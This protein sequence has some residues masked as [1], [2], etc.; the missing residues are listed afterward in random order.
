MYMKQSIQDQYKQL[1]QEII[2][3]S[4]QYHTHDNPEISDE[5]YDALVRELIHLEKQYP[6]LVTTDT[7]TTRVG[8]KILDGF[9]KINHIVPQWSYDNVFN[10]DELEQWRQR[11]TKILIKDW[12]N[13]K[14]TEYIAELKIDGL[15][16]VLTYQNGKLITGAT[17]GDGAVGENVTE[18]ILQITS[19]PKTISDTRHMVIMGEIWIEKSELEKINIERAMLD[20]PAYANPRNLAAGTLR[21]L[22]TSIVAE[23]NLQAFIYDVEFIND[24]GFATHRDELVFLKNQGFVVNEHYYQCKTLDEIEHIYQDWC[25]KREDK[26]YGIDGLVIKINDKDQ[27][28]QLGYTAKSPRFG[29][30]YKFPAVE[31]TTIVE[32]IDVQV[33]RTGVLTPVAHVRPVSVAGS[34]VSRA[35]LHNQDQIDSLDIRIGDTVILRKAGDIIPEI[36]GVLLPLRPKKTTRFIIPN[37]CPACGAP[38]ARRENT[39][40][41]ETVALFCTNKKCPAQVLGNLIHYASKGAMNIVGMGEKIVEK[42]VD[43]KLI[44]NPVDIYHLQKS[45]LEQLEKFG[46]LSASNLITS[47]ESSKTV[48]L[49][50][51]LFALGIPHIGIE[52]A[53]LIAD[54]LTWS[55]PTELTKQL[56]GLTLNHLVDIHGIGERVA[57][58]Y[59]DYISDE[60]NQKMMRELLELLTIQQ[61]KKSSQKLNGKTFVITGTLP[62]LSREQATQIIKDNGGK[63]SSSV[64]KKTDYVL[65]GT[66]AGSKYDTAV[67]LEVVIIDEEQF[68]SLLQ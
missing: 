19:I 48:T 35:T 13:T 14:P 7:V 10:L 36:V 59:L 39:T 1:Q 55:S 50:R 23:R 17:R 5:A 28:R 56:L 57:E 51:F 58:S 42:L 9:E 11:N 54:S 38:S 18:N 30:A 63:V 46:D 67:K 47:I 16:I 21:Q 64:S 31:V 49:D 22:D 53:G 2:H 61:I 62:T 29:I 37:Q 68:K 27:C 34:V 25:N 12:E 66:D 15:K 43:E 33:G 32:D 20:L 24:D 6:E 3:H 45:D 52:T 41:S 26:E 8:G 4:E 44:T 65:A 60:Q 40:V